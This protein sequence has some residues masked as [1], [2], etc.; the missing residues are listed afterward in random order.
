MRGDALGAAERD[1]ERQRIF[2]IRAAAALAAQRDGEFAAGED[3]DAPAL[4]G[5]VAGEPGMVRR[6]PRGPRLAAGRRG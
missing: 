3:R 1:G 5:E 2:L 4:C 6:R